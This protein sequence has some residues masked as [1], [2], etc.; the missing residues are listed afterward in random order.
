MT[1]RNASP[2]DHSTM[3]ASKAGAQRTAL[4]LIDVIAAFFAAAASAYYPDSAGCCR[5]R[6]GLCRWFRALG[7]SRGDRGAKRRYSAFYATDLDVL[8]RG[9]GIERLV[10]AGVKTNVCVQATIQ[11]AFAT[12]A[13]AGASPTSPSWNWR[14]ERRPV[15]LAAA[16][17][18]TPH[19]RTQC[20][21]HIRQALHPRE[22]AS[23]PDVPPESPGHVRGNTPSTQRRYG[24]TPQISP[25]SSSSRHCL[26]QQ[27]S[28]LMHENPF[29]VHA[30]T[31]GNSRPMSIAV[32]RSVSCAALP[33]ISAVLVNSA[34]GIA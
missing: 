32:S 2:N 28:L 17:T 9:Q 34:V 7:L 3:A 30:R 8:L 14:N 29:G 11:D 4:V 31:V 18:N 24:Y 20:H 16:H 6:V 12:G 5:R 33:V 15:L 19:H 10:I 22:S 26:E 27:S 21:A 1:S 13:S 25:S 23:A